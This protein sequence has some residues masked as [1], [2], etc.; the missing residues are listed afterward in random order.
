MIEIEL[1]SVQWLNINDLPS[2]KWKDITG[3]EGLYQISNYGR[4]KSLER[5]IKANKNCPK[6]RKVKS[7]ILKQTSSICNRYLFVN[8]CNKE[9]DKKSTNVHRLVALAFIP[10]PNKYPVV[11][12][13]DDNKLN[14]K[15]TN[16]L[17]GTYSENIQSSYDNGLNKRNR[18]VVQYTKDNKFIKEYSSI[19]NA[20][21]ENNLLVTSIA[22]C[23]SNRAKTSGGYIWK[24]KEREE[25]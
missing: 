16:L 14:N 2:E 19:T 5:Y 25:D 13:K 12:H 9:G 24:Y 3:Y 11:M 15:V 18:Y 7:K 17:W 23:L 22:N 6:G 20:S 4:V 1:N 21:K 10:N 8:L